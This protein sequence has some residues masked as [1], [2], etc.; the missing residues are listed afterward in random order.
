MAQSLGIPFF[1]QTKTHAF[2][3][4]F[5]HFYLLLSLFKHIALPTLLVNTVYSYSALFPFHTYTGYLFVLILAPVLF[6]VKSL[7][8]KKIAFEGHSTENLQC[9]GNVLFCFCKCLTEQNARRICT[10]LEAI[11]KIGCVRTGFIL[12]PVII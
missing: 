7:L 4:L 12:S 9:Y 5:F 2:Q 6:F 8:I 1:L 11:L 10:V 3:P